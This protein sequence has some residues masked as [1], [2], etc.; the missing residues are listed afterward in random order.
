M[1]AVCR[2]IED[3][4]VAFA[5]EPLAKG[6]PTFYPPVLGAGILSGGG[7]SRLWIAS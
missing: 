3:L 1:K 5:I 7:S 2:E 4:G 6:K